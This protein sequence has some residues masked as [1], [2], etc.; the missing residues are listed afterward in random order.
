MLWR[1]E[2]LYSDHYL[3]KR[4]PTSS[5]FPST[6]DAEAL[7]GYVNG[8][9]ALGSALFKANEEDTEKRFITPLLSHLG[10]AH[11]NR[12][13]IPGASRLPDYLLYADAEHEKEAFATGNHFDH[14]VALLE[15]KRFGRNLS[16][17]GRDDLRSPHQQIRGYL[18]DA[19]VPWG[20]LTNGSRWRL[21]FRDDRPSAYFEFDLRAAVERNDLDALRIFLALFSAPALT[22]D[23]GGKRAVDLARDESVRYRA[24]VEQRL[25]EQVFEGVE[26]LA[27]GFL[28]HPANQLSRDALRTIYE[29][30]LVF[31]YRVL[32]VLNAEARELLPTTPSSERA[33]RYI[34]GY[35]IEKIRHVLMDPVAKEQYSDSTSTQLYDRLRGLFRLI[36]GRPP[37]SGQKDPNAELGIPRYNGGLFDPT[38]HPFLDQH[39]VGDQAL[40]H[41]LERLLLRTDSDGITSFDYANLGERHLGSI[42]EGLLE[43][44]LV[45]EEQSLAPCLKNDRG[46]RKT[47]GAYYTPEPLVVLLVRETLTPILENIEHNLEGY[48]VRN[49]PEAGVLSDK[50]PDDSFA[51]A[52]LRLNVCDPAMGSGHFLVEVVQELAESVAAHP[53]TRLRPELNADGKPSHR[54]DGSGEPIF[55]F[56]ATLSYWKRRIVEAC[57]YGVDLNPLAVEL[58]KLSLWLKTVDRVPLNFLDHHLRCGNA[59]IGVPLRALPKYITPGK[60]KSPDWT[61]PAQFTLEFQQALET[62]ICSAITTIS[63]IEGTE[64]DTHEAAKHKESLWRQISEQTMPQF[65]AV[66]D[67]WVAPWLGSK[68]GFAE[69]ERALNDLAIAVSERDKAVDVLEQHRP[70]H[71]E[72]EFPDVFFGPDGQLLRSGGFDAVIGNPPW[73]RIKLQENEFFSARS[74]AISR[75]PKASDR[76]ALIAKL[77]TSK[78][79]ADQKLWK[80]YELAKDGAER[81][82]WFLQK[83]GFYPKMGRGDTNLYAVFAEK[84]LGLLSATGRLGMLMPSG[85]ASD[86]GNAEFF[87]G[88]ATSGRIAGLY[89]FENRLPYF[90]DVDSRFKFCAFLA[91]GS[92]VETTV[93]RCAFFL[94]RVEEMDEPNRVFTMSPEDYRLFNP[95]T[96][97]API[98]RYQR[99]AE[100]TRRI[101]ERVPVLLLRNRVE[102][103]RQILEA[104]PWGVSFLRMFDMTNDSKLF[105]TADELEAQGCY[106]LAGSIYAKGNDRYLPLY[107]GKMVQAFDHR[108]ATIR[109]NAANVHRPAQ[110][111][112]I[113]EK[114]KRDPSF[115]VKPLYWVWH[116]NVPVTSNGWRLAYKD[117]T[118]PTNVRSMIASA[119]PD[120]ACGNTLCLITAV[121]GEQALLLANLNAMV[122][123]FAARQKIGGQHLNFFIVEQLPV[124][125]PKAYTEQIG[126][127]TREAF[128]L[129]RVLELSYTAD[130][131]QA[132]A[133]SLGYTGLPFQWD[134]ERRLHLRC[135]LDAM[136][137]LAYGLSKEDAEYVLSTFPIVE[138]QDT[139][140]YGRY[141][142]RDLILHYMSAYAVGDTDAWIDA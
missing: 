120:T 112:P 10:Y 103:N 13:Q 53:T 136:Y 47:S 20:I 27:Q 40:A 37:R 116:K 74:A 60:P 70:F 16:E 109:I 63:E 61:Q 92:A 135:Q 30:S 131:L 50:D 2:G 5:G 4:L 88:L 29:N 73:E 65:K 14:C 43:H 95:N 7:V 1:C 107:E 124:L 81:T 31:L 76:K 45:W 72:F 90:A 67:L 139:A 84:A 38:K 126:K 18:N 93:A 97:T 105:H 125:P 130:D 108:A 127:I 49:D 113:D 6:Q 35:G 128:V 100:L 58:A 33:R 118:A 87:G 28:E 3:T 64:T 48:A 39:V 119:V 91:T 111:V 114:Q 51:E 62:A 122:L 66:A 99:D 11:A 142:S 82:A 25:R 138:R 115:C 32:F 89:D 79:E 129:P 17:K 132:F 117:V 68:T 9:L 69:H 137:F 36:N 94:H 8:L 34:E 71:W 24:E 133:S 19:L 86:A 42:Y 44:T 54:S 15:A 110:E 140:R 78:D 102:G 75:A 41:V 22:P 56:E 85:I 96:G 12:R 52:V 55:T 80:E 83:S 123:D 59:L 121:Q 134:E 104:N 101:Y 98:F 21:Y 57:I 23:G 106:P 46:E 77:R 26:R 141:R